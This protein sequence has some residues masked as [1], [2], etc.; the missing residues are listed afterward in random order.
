MINQYMGVAPTTFQVVYLNHSGDSS[1]LKWIV[2]GWMRWDG[3]FWVWL[4]ALKLIQHLKIDGWKM[5]FLLGMPIFRGYVSLTLKDKS[6]WQGMWKMSWFR[7]P[8][9]TFEGVFER[10][11]ITTLKL[12]LRLRLCT[13]PFVIAYSSGASCWVQGASKLQKCI[14]RSFR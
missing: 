3:F 2:V 14:R 12:K 1:C 7:V 5:N 8:C 4:P 9:L 6:R 10:L 13:F 11:F